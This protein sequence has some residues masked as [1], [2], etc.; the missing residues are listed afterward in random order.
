MYIN[1]HL[2]PLSFRELFNTMFYVLSHA[3]HGCS[4]VVH[5]LYQVMMLFFSSSGF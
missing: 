4:I 5:N 2:Q 3:L 1:E